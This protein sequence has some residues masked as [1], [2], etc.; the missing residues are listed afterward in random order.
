MPRPFDII[1]PSWNNLPYLQNCIDGI[2]SHSETAHHLIVH[3]NEGSDGT[4]AWLEKEGISFTYSEENIGICAAFNRAMQLA[5]HDFLLYMNDDMYAL[6]GWD[7]ALSLRIPE[8]SLWMLSA[9]MIE[10]RHGGNP[11]VVEA[12]FGRSLEQFRK[13]ELIRQV[14]RLKRA[15]WSGSA[16]PPLL[17]PRQAIE[18]VGGFSM[19]FSPGMYSDPDL[20]MKFWKLGNRFFLGVGDSLVYHFQARSTGRVV[21]NNGRLTFMK[22]WGITASA[23]YKYYLRMGRKPILP[24][25]EPP[26]RRLLPNRMRVKL[27]SMIW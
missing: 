21:K 19:E 5:K 25:S 12:D 11:V 24:L 23:F 4:A 18:A 10:P 7:R 20:A 16:W 15:D 8:G 9:T 1:I 14:D 22:K 2:R 27:K 13:A 17:M 26:A 6:P 3:V